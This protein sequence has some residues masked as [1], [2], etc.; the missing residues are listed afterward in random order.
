MR[1]LRRLVILTPMITAI[2][3]AGGVT[4]ALAFF[5]LPAAD[6]SPAPRPRG[7]TLPAPTAAEPSRP[8]AATEHPQ[9]APTPTPPPSD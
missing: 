5:V 3:V 6:E 9:S 1:L 7:T 2:L 4:A 8:A